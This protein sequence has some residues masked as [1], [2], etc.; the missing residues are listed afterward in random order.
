MLTHVVVTL[1][2]NVLMH[3]LE[4]IIMTDMGNLD[5]NQGQGLPYVFFIM[6]IK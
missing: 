1:L 2:L 3:A 5:P 4:K 6:Y